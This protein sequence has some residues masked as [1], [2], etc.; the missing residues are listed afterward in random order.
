MSI[1]WPAW[2][3]V[4][5]AVRFGVTSQAN[6]VVPL[7]TAEAMRCLDDLFGSW[8]T[9]LLPGRLDLQELDVHRG[10]GV[11]ATMRMLN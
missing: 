1:N 8:L 3:E 4:G 2:A 5:M 6:T 7:T 9:P 10:G 11:P